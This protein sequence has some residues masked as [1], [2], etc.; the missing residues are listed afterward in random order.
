MGEVI[1]AVAV[2]S[3]SVEQRIFFVHIPR[4]GGTTVEALMREHLDGTFFTGYWDGPIL[5]RHRSFKDEADYF[6]GHNFYYV[7]DVI[8]A[9]NFAFTFLR[10]PIERAVSL[11]NFMVEHKPDKA[12]EYDGFMDAVRRHRHFSNHQVRFLATR[13]DARVTYA[14]LQGREITREEVL[15][16][17]KRNRGVPMERTDYLVARSIVE[18]LD[19]FGVFDHFED[20]VARLFGTWGID[21]ELPLPHE[22]RP[23]SAQV[24]VDDLSEG[25]R[26]FIEQQ[27]PWDSRL[28]EHA[29][30]V[31][32]ERHGIAS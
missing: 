27:N 12:A 13:Y 9:P 17:V 19:F 2:H 14:K 22:R 16:E 32:R 31:Y 18:D 26:S 5:V 8:P 1:A 3:R 30:G 25:D 23:S 10:D 11:W 28:Y 21:L 6:I 29:L 24:H 4:T 20:A 7:R 15:D